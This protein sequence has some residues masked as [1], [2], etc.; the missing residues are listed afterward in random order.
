[1]REQISTLYSMR[2]L[3]VT[4]DIYSNRIKWNK[5]AKATFTYYI[6]RKL[7]IYFKS[8]AI[9]YANIEPF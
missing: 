5:N 4:N 7:N 1:M 6:V 2:R 8:Q 3:S 9:F